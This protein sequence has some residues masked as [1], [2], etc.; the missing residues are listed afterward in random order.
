MFY[1]D[2]FIGN[3]LYHMLPLF[4]RWFVTESDG[5]RLHGV[6]YQEPVHFLYSKAKE[7]ILTLQPRTMRRPTV[8]ANSD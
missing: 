3:L 5:L 4:E 7:E 8:A 6:N 1:D 2:N